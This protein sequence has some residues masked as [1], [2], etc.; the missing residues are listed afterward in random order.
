MMTWAIISVLS[1]TQFVDRG[2]RFPTKAKCNQA[3]KSKRIHFPQVALL[4]ND[5]FLQCVGLPDKYEPPKPVSKPKVVTK[6]VT[7]YKQRGNN[8]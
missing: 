5:D 7:G 8:A 2:I 6:Q 4:N 3:L 1:A